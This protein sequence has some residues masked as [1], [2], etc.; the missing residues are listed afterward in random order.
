M[1]RYDIEQ[2]RC[3]DCHHRVVGRDAGQVSDATGAAAAQIGPRA[4]ALA[5]VLH[6]ELGIP[7]AKTAKVLA[8][9]GGLSITPDG[10]S[11]ALA[12]AARRAQ[13]TDD[14]LVAGIRHS[15]VVAPDETG[16]RVNG[17]KKWL[18]VFAGQGITVYRIFDSCGYDHA[19]QVLGEDFSGVLERD[20]WAP[21]RKFAKASH[22]TCYAHLARR[23][24]EMIADAA[25]GH[26]HIPA[27]VAKI[28]QDALVLRAARD[29]GHLDPQALAQRVVDLNERVDLLLAGEVACCQPDR[30]LV[31]H[32]R[33]ERDA[34][35]TFLAL[36]GVA[37]T[38]WRAEQGIRPIVVNRKQWGGNRTR[39]GAD[40]TQVL[41]SLLRSARQQHRDPVEV[42]TP[43]LTSPT[44]IV[45]G[46]V[47]PG[48]DPTNLIT[49]AQPGP[50]P[51]RAA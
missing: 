30:R 7:H 44:P 18:W 49:P 51:P 8:Q 26:T 15:P 46:L 5:A 31:K 39:Q 12:R 1:T 6:H 24:R 47:I 21:Y 4:L 37:A 32:L 23:C 43:L 45:A 40:T 2:G 17:A 11:Q 14:A 33:N 36:P 28:L 3:A 41:A 42:L 13:A 20:G 48:R 29:A 50:A 38:N 27:A 35:F 16:W 22:Q 25:E 19:E 34:L 10:L 9:L